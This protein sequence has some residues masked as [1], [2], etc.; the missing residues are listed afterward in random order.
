MNLRHFT[1]PERRRRFV[2][3]AFV[4][5][6]LAAVAGGF[7]ILDRFDRIPGEESPTPL[8]WPESTMLAWS[9]GRVNSATPR[10]TL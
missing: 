8:Q 4:S 9:A 7:A 5:A 3:F 1:H 10:I 6:W 2:R